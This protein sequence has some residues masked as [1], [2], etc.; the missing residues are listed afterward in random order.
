MSDLQPAA[1]SQDELRNYQ[2]RIVVFGSRYFS[3]YKL[4]SECMFDYLK[5]NNIQKGEVIFLSG[6][7]MMDR[8]KKEEQTGADAFI[9]HW[10]IEHGYPWTEHWA[11]WSDV[12]SN[13]AIVRYKKGRPYNVLAGFVRNEEMAELCNRGITF[14]DGASTGTKDMITRMARRQH[15]VRLIQYQQS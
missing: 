13:S 12:S 6:M 11:N 10:C 3:D 5:E 8:V 15:P 7:A 4:F 2:H 14:Y 1:S 9:V